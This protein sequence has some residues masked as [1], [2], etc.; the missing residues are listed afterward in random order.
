MASEN[1]AKLALL[2][3]ADNA[4]PSAVEGLLVEVAKYGTAHVKRAYGDWTG[5]RLAGWKE[6]LLAQYIIQPI[7]PIQQFAYTTG[8]NSTDAALVIDA[9]DLLYTG[10]FDG[11]RVDPAYTEPVPPR[12]HAL[13]AE[14]EEI[15]ELFAGWR[16]ELVCDVP[17]LASLFLPRSCR[18][19]GV[20]RS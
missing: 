14:R 12:V 3:D 13:P 2:I 17:R 11:S 4:Q 19:W 9:M 1:A 7:Q 8:K 16:E 6:R 10:R 20:V 15:E 5:P 18:G